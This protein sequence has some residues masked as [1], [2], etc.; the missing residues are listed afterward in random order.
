M[1]VSLIEEFIILTRGHHALLALSWQLLV[2]IIRIGVC[3]KACEV[4]VDLLCSLLIEWKKSATFVISA[5]P[6]APVALRN[7]RDMSYH[8]SCAVLGFPQPVL[9]ASRLRLHLHL[10]IHLSLNHEGCCGTTG[11]LTTQYIG[12]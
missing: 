10:H 8:L 5:L 4:G 12:L 11:D 6:L 2:S 9:S 1:V 7:I 3:R